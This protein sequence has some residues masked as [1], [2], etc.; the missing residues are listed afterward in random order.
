[1]F[2]QPVDVDLSVEVETR[3]NLKD[4]ERIV[5]S[6]TAAQIQH[7][8]LPDTGRRSE[9]EFPRLTKANYSAS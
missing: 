7:E 4:R 9:E 6:Q 5:V 3:L 1:M 2:L 8:P